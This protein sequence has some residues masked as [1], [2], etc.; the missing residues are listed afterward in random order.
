[1]VTYGKRKLIFT[2]IHKPLPHVLL[3]EESLAQESQIEWRLFVKTLAMTINNFRLTSGL[4][5]LLKGSPTFH[6]RPRQRCRPGGGCVCLH[7]VNYLSQYQ[8]NPFAAS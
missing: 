7:E 3:A 6:R 1:M 4:T 8:H 5:L 2:I